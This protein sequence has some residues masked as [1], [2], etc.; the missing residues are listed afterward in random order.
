MHKIQFFRALVLPILKALD[1]DLT[2]KHHYTGDPFTLSLFAHKG[3][4]FHGRN[5]ERLEM[6]SI[7]SLVSPGYVVAE[8]GG[9]IG[10]LSLHFAQCAQ[11]SESGKVF[12]CV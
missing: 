5:R 9:H 4:W 3:Y 11:T 7:E 8:V 2:I 12:F 1:R 10:Y 6:L